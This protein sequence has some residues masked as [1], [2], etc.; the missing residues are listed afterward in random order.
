[1]K[2]RLEIFITVVVSALFIYLLIYSFGI[3]GVR[4]SKLEQE[5]RRSQHIDK[6]WSVEKAVSDNMG[7]LIF[8][9]ESS[10]ESVF[11]I[12]LNRD[13]FSFGY[14]FYAGGSVGAITDGVTEFI[15]ADYGSALLSMNHDKVEKIVFGN[16]S[17]S[18]ILVDPSKPFTVILPDNCESFELYDVNGK[19][20][21]IKVYAN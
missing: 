18:P 15:Y 8:Y 13:G 10:D 20:I 5:A 9:D 21:P 3:L 14:F 2:K 17:I 19:S 7:S 12:Y 4:A 6:S 1:M 16:T 11:S